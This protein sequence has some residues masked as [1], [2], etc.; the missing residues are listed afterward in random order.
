VDYM[1]FMLFNP[2]DGSKLF[3]WDIAE[4]LPNVQSFSNALDLTI[5]FI[6][7]SKYFLVQWEFH[8]LPTHLLCSFSC[9]RKGNALSCI[10]RVWWSRTPS[11]QICSSYPIRIVLR[12]D[13]WL[14][15]KW[16]VTVYILYSLGKSKL[17]KL[18]EPCSCLGS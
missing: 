14:L 9:L 3:F 15:W 17:I 1:L 4:I 7:R 2:E 8:V 5:I 13:C 16:S 12:S 6:S 10:R 11:E 18:W